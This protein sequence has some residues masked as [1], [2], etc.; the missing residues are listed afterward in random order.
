M[1][2]RMMGDRNYFVMDSAK[3][4]ELMA[5]IFT[6]SKYQ[7]WQQQNSSDS[8]GSSRGFKGAI[9]ARR[10]RNGKR[11]ET[12]LPAGESCAGYGK[13][14]RWDFPSGRGIEYFL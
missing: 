7:E 5:S 12:T 8:A 10:W 6:P 13:D 3:T 1:G 11:P 14:H 4:K 9:I 2:Q